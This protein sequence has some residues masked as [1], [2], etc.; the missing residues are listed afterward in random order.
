[1]QLLP[2]ITV[3]ANRLAN[4]IVLLFRVLEL[5][6]FL[7]ANKMPFHLQELTFPL[8]KMIRIGPIQ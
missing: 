4:E 6:V 7:A 8:K 2:V 1:M 5:S 3:S